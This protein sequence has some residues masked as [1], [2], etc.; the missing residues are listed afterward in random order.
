MCELKEILCTLGCWVIFWF[1]VLM[2]WGD[3]LLKCFDFHFLFLQ[4]AALISYFCS[5]LCILQCLVFLHFQDQL[6][7]E[8]RV[9]VAGWICSVD[10]TL[11]CSC[12]EMQC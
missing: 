12:S 1:Y 11:F 10:S 3:F 4:R 2:L 5:F 9:W 7:A 8:V 6:K